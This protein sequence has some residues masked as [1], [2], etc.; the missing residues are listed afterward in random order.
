M[1]RFVPRLPPMQ[2]VVEVEFLGADFNPPSFFRRHAREIVIAD[3]E[4]RED[5]DHDEPVLSPMTGKV[6]YIYPTAPTRLIEVVSSNARLWQLACLLERELRH[7]TDPVLNPLS[8]PKSGI[9]Y[10]PLHFRHR[11]SGTLL[12]P[13]RTSVPWVIEIRKEVSHLRLFRRRLAEVTAE[14]G[15]LILE[16]A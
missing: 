11:T 6:R 3:L 7:V 10:F 8:I 15:T 5:I 16:G 12:R 2:R 14:P 9:T 13:E 1:V 4:L